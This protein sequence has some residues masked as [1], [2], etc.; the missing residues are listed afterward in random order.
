MVLEW[1]WFRVRTQNDDDDDDDYDDDDD[2]PSAS[3]PLSN[4][5]TDITVST[6]PKIGRINTEDEEPPND[7]AILVLTDIPTLP[8]T[9]QATVQV[10]GFTLPPT[11]SPEESTSPSTQDLLTQKVKNPTK[12]TPLLSYYLQYCKLWLIMMTI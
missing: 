7:N 12:I 5:Q 1:I 10:G 3:P 2:F 8:P 4:A 6:S 11:S 9:S